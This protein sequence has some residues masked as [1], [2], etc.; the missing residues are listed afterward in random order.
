MQQFRRAVFLWIALFVL[1]M[2]GFATSFTFTSIE[3]SDIAG[4]QVTGI[5]NAGQ[6]SG[7]GGA[8]EVQKGFVLDISGIVTTIFQPSSN[9][10]Q[11]FGLNDSGQVVGTFSD[12][13]GRHAFVSNGAALTPINVPNSAATSANGVNAA[14]QIVGDFTGSGVT[15]GFVYSSG[16]FATVYF[17]G[18]T[19]TQAF[20]INSGGQIVGTYLDSSGGHHAF[21][22][23]NG[24]YTPLNVPGADTSDAYGINGTSKIVGTFS[25]STGTQGFLDDNGVFSTIAVPEAS[26]TYA[27]AINDAGQIVGNYFDEQGYPHPFLATPSA[28]I[29]ESEPLVLIAFGLL[30]IVIGR[31]GPTRGKLIDSPQSGVQKE[32]LM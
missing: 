25:S 24:V 4:P 14:E 27:L 15:Q 9:S 22:Y 32:R 31:I 13:L 19:G 21:I 1:T 7:Y 28:V 3:V 18:S 6:I 11:S 29:P 5:N 26:A 2:P 17:A 10:T 16:A 8:G 30:A 20:G 12:V 23:N